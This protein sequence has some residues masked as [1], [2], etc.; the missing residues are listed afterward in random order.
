LGAQIPGGIPK[1]DIGGLLSRAQQAMEIANV[2][3]DE[4]IRRLGIV[5]PEKQ[6]TED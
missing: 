4:V 2:L 1:A 3:Q 5:E 6:Y